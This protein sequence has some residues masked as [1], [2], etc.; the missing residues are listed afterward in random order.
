MPR[1]YRARATRPADP[2]PHWVLVFLATGQVNY[3]EAGIAAFAGE[4]SGTC[5][6]EPLRP[7]LDPFVRER[8]AKAWATFGAAF[9]SRRAEVEALCPRGKK[10][11]FSHRLAQARREGAPPRVDGPA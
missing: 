2:V 11:W 5:E 3:H 4:F 7:E 8:Y 10:P 1:P 9:Q 6:L